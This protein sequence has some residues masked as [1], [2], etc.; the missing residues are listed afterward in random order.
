MS[1]M[2]T[3]FD[4]D[5]SGVDSLEIGASSWDLHAFFVSYWS[6]KAR[7][8]FCMPGGEVKSILRSSF[9]VV[10]WGFPYVNTRGSIIVSKVNI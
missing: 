6:L 10:A 8:G 9:K 7:K 1:S 3:Y 4:L 2:L 5:L